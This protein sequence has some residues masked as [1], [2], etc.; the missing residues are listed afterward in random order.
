MIL[1]KMVLGLSLIALASPTVTVKTITNP[2]T[3]T[4]DMIVGGTNGSPLAPDTITV[5]E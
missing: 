5:M 1:Q 4:G 3:T 2:M